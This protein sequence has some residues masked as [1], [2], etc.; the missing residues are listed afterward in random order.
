M[1]ADVLPRRLQE[2]FRLPALT[3]RYPPAGTPAPRQPL[4]PRQPSATRMTVLAAYDAGINFFFLTA[5]MHWPIYE[6]LRR[7]LELLFARGA[8]VR[9]SVVVSVVSYVTQPE[10]C[11]A[12]FVE[13]TRA[14]RGMDRVDLSIIGGAYGGEL[15]VRLREY[16]SA[17]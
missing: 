4:L 12:P 13:A 14:V 17:P 9:D 15:L 8:S 7:G 16:R 5:D 6:T 1:S 11:Y 10:F 2:S 3:D